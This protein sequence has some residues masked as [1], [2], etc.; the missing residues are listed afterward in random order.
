V[1]G[2]N[3]GFTDH[4]PVAPVDA[5]VAFVQL[6]GSIEQSVQFTAGTYVI[7]AKAAQRGI[8][9]L[10]AQTVEVYVDSQKVGSFSPGGTA[11]SAVSTGVFTVTQGAHTVK[12]VGLATQDASLF[13]DGVSIASTVLAGTPTAPVA[14]YVTIAGAGFE[15]PNL[16]TDNFYAFSYRLTGSPWSFEGN[17]GIAGNNSGFTEYASHA[18]EG[19]QAAF[20]QG[21]NGVV[22]Q[23]LAFASSG[24]F[25]LVLSAASR[26]GP[27]NKGD[28]VVEV[29]L[30]GTVIGSFSPTSTSYQS[31][32]LSFATTAG[33]HVLSFQ[34]TVSVDATA[35]IDDIVIIGP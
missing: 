26:G 35:L 17:S 27:W 4:N 1:T 33:D 8:W 14:Q 21:E 30:D 7:K 24:H 20:I 32:S 15:A 16:G 25:S 28:Q 19:T 2:N 3:S 11:Y 10:Q 13:I 23:S 6:Q 34:G 18:P 12:F 5:Q 22:S 9:Q 31:F 29:L